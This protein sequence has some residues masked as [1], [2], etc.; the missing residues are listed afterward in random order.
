MKNGHTDP[1]KHR[2]CCFCDKVDSGL[3]YILAGNDDIYQSFEEFEIQ[4]DPTTDLGVSCPCAS[5]KK[6]PVDL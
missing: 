6:I 3:V 2:Q 5:E 4:P 1:L